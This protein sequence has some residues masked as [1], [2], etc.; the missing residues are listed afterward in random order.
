MMMLKI[1]SNL[2]FALFYSSYP[3]CQKVY[4][5]IKALRE[6]L[7]NARVAL[8]HNINTIILCIILLQVRSYSKV[9]IVGVQGCLGNFTNIVNQLTKKN[10]ENISH[11]EVPT[12]LMHQG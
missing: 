5:I 12:E 9:K 7:P 11:I 10:C 3:L 8:Q 2:L 4:A 1:F 6:Y